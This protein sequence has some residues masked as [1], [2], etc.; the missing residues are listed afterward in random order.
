MAIETG[1]RFIKGSG[2]N[3]DEIP[4]QSGGRKKKNSEASE[5]VKSLFGYTIVD[6]EEEETFS[7][8]KLLGALKVG[9]GVQI[10]KADFGK[11]NSAVHIYTKFSKK[12]FGGAR[13]FKFKRDRDAKNQPARGVGLVWRVK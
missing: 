12:H 9:Q 2:I 10:V 3:L 7:W 13:A 1:E 4:G 11:A 5:P 6:V 8:Q